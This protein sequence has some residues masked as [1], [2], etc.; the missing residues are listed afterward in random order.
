M[1]SPVRAARPSPNRAV[2]F[3]RFLVALMAAGSLGVVSCSSPSRVAPAS[4]NPPASDGAYETAPAAS[5][6][7]P[8][9]SHTIDALAAGARGDGI[10]DDS[11]AIQRALDRLEGGGTL[12]FPPG[13]YLQSRVLVVEHDD[14]RVEG[15]P[16]ATIEATR[17]DEVAIVLRGDR[18]AISG[19][20]LTAP[21]AAAR[22]G[23]LE[24]HRIV[25]EAG[26]GQQVQGNHVVGGPA[27]GIFVYG[28]SGFTVADNDVERTKADGIHL[29]AGAADGRVVGNRVRQVED[30]CVA[31]VSY[32]QD[33]AVVHDVLEEGNTCTDIVRGRGFSVVGGQDITIRDGRIDGTWAAA[34]Y[35]ASEGS[36]DTYAAHRVQ[37]VGNRISRANTEAELGHGAI[38]LV[39]RPGRARLRDATVSLRNEDILL[40]DNTIDATVASIADIVLLGPHQVRVAIEG[41]TIRGDPARPAFAF[42][43]VDDEE[44]TL[45]GNTFNGSPLPERAGPTPAAPR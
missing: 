30:D 38:M 41:Q 42:D 23:A 13:T 24:H 1:T 45:R 43:Q 35:L 39:A 31:V 19:L 32:I 10:T 40:A 11:D 25:L 28:A 37:V 26:S 14:V 17:E 36:F 44:V 5:A 9:S 21:A 34:V 3:A 33:D 18:T 22:L 8:T 15:A 12:L 2:L 27:A 4:S 29:T 20:T 16:G 7:G 6:V